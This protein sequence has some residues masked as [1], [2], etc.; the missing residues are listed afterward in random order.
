MRL[1]ATGG[2]DSDDGRVAVPDS[3]GTPAWRTQRSVVSRWAL[4]GTEALPSVE[5]FSGRGL[6]GTL[7]YRRRVY[8]AP[9]LVGRSGDR[10]RGDVGHVVVFLFGVPVFRVFDALGESPRGEVGLVQIPAET[11]DGFLVE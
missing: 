1:I 10:G 11:L 9:W 3:L 8:G 4:S 5:L 7:R 6:A 2:Y